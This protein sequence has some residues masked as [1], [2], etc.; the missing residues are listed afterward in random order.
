MA[1]ESGGLGHC[2]QVQTHDLQSLNWLVASEA[3]ISA[4]S[5]TLTISVFV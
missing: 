2:S 4:Y 5:E 1:E 3:S